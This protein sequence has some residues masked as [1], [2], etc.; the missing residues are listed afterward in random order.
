M[1]ESLKRELKIWK[2]K[3]TVWVPYSFPTLPSSIFYSWLW[4]VPHWKC[5]L[6]SLFEWKL[7]LKCLWRP[8]QALLIDNSEK[9]VGASTHPCLTPLAT[10]KYL[11]TKPLIATL[12]YIPVRSA[13]IRLTKFFVQPYFLSTCRDL[14]SLSRYNI[15]GFTEF[16]E[17]CIWRQVLFD[18]LFLN[19]SQAENQRCVHWACL[20][21]RVRESYQH[22]PAVIYLGNFHN[23]SCHLFL[24]KGTILASFQSWGTFWASYISWMNLRRQW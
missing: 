6:L 13:S 20:E 2:K 10:E 21:V 5:L 11:D 12:A 7:L 19:L 18:T 8:P 9:R 3:A 24:N 15:E 4:S 23:F 1:R 17:D 16:N 22:W 14:K